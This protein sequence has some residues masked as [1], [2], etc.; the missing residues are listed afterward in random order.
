M[1]NIF[2]TNVTFNALKKPVAGQINLWKWKWIGHTLE[3]KV[4]LILTWDYFKISSHDLR[5]SE[6]IISAVH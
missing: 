5:G 2:W 6:K 1:F 4:T 3:E